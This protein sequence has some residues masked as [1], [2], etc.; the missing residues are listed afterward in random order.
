MGEWYDGMIVQFCGDGSSIVEVSSM[1]VVTAVV[2]AAMVTWQQR[3]GGVSDGSGFGCGSGDKR[4]LIVVQWRC[5]RLKWL[6][7]WQW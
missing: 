2:D 3:G 7:I 1:E 5:P 4:M 6:W